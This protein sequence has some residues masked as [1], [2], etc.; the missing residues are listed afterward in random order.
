MVGVRGATTFGHGRG[1]SESRRD[2]GSDFARFSFY[3]L[4]P[5]L[6]RPTRLFRVLPRLDIP[7]ITYPHTR[8]ILTMGHRE[9]CPCC[10]QQVTKGVLKKHAAEAKRRQHVI[11]MGGDPTSPAVTLKVKP[12]TGNDTFGSRAQVPAPTVTLLTFDEDTSD[13]N[14]GITPPPPSVPPPRHFI[15][16]HSIKDDDFP[17]DPVE[18]DHDPPQFSDPPNCYPSMET[19]DSDEDEDKAEHEGEVPDNEP[20]LEEFM[21]WEYLKQGNSHLCILYHIRGQ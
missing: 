13:S 7:F 15:S 6:P 11:V 4:R 5:T 16:P 14:L 18:H 8:T 17:P 1:R 20:D 21:D 19:S 3:A 12:I 9:W 10:S 2:R